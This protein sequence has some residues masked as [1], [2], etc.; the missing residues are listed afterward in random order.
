MFCLIILSCHKYEA[1]RQRQRATWLRDSPIP[2]WFHVRGD[3]TLA[4]DWQFD[5]SEHLLTVRT[6]DDYASLCKK[7][8]T[9]LQAIR[10]TYPA[11]THILKTDDDMDCNAAALRRLLGAFAAY[12]YGGAFTV[13][14]TDRL[15]TYHYHSVDDKTPAIVSACKYASGRFYFVSAKATDCILRKKELFWSRMFEDNTVGYALHNEPGI[16]LLPVPDKLCFKEWS[17]EIAHRS[18]SQ[19]SILKSG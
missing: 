1:K 6:P 17:D 2:L 8:W 12:D 15:S 19:M 5:E 7:T 4:T 11:V 18:F 13:I 16:S 10:E 3:E 14:P 9:A